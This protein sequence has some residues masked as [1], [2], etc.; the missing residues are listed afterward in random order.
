MARRVSYRV[1]AYGTTNTYV[2]TWLAAREALEKA[3]QVKRGE[4]SFCMMAGV[5]AAFTVEAYLNH[6]G[7]KEMRDWGALE[8]KL[9]PREKLLLLR[10][11][12]CWTVD[13]DNRLFAT[14]TRMLKLRNELAHGKT[15]TKHKDV[16]FN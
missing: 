5:F 6:V 16:T 14:L 11:T 10:Q 7:L 9:G 15:V 13:L 1:K 3:E 4:F 8:P 12:E 2:S